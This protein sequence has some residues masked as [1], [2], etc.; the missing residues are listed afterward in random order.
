[1]I[2]V[3][4]LTPNQIPFIQSA[5]PFQNPE[6]QHQAGEIENAVLGFCRST[7]DN[8][9]HLGGTAIR[10]SAKCAQELGEKE[11]KSA[12]DKWIEASASGT[13]KYILH[14]AMRLSNRYSELK[15]RLQKLAREHVQLWGLRALDTLFSVDERFFELMI[16]RG[17]KSH[18]AIKNADNLLQGKLPNLS[19]G[20]FVEI[21][22][23]DEASGSTG[24]LRHNHRQGRIW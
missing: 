13:G 11:G 20:T 1:M 18:K 14:V 21:V 7:F 22:S 9:L 8:L 5:S 12:F 10:F 3:T 15:P 16:K 23:S 17:K 2:S 4:E 19:K 6:L 24:R